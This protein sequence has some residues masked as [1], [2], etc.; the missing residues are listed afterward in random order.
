M[1]SKGQSGI[2]PQVAS[3]HDLRQF[4]YSAD[5]SRA[6]GDLLRPP[7]GLFVARIGAR[8]AQQA[9]P[10]K[11]DRLLVKVTQ[12]FTRSDTFLKFPPVWA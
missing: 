5:A 6:I 10:V 8:K 12:R 9:A 1:I 4:H 3:C 2:A 7:Q 11:S